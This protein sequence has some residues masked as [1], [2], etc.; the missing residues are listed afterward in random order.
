MRGAIVGAWRSAGWE[1]GHYGYPTSDE[2]CRTMA[3]GAGRCRQTYQGGA[4]TWRSDIGVIDCARLKCIAL[5]FDDG[6]S[7]Y[8]SRLVDILDANNVNATFFAVGQNVGGYPST[9]RRSYEK[10][11]EIMNHSWSHPDLT[12]LSA[13][14]VSSEL[15]R[16]SDAIG[17]TVG[18]RPTLVRPPYGSYNSTV[19]SVAGQQGMAVILWNNDTLDWSNRNTA[20][21]ISRATSSATPGGIILMHDLYPTTVDA[22]PTIIG[23]LK[24]RGYALVSVS[25]VIGNP[26]P[27]RVYSRRP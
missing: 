10:G 27:G 24:A 6:P 26:Q 23:N 5:T 8:T 14:G 2:L 17:S 3:G 16:T 12:G 25:D 18:R 9:V 15:S 19:T 7:Q 22:V 21:I 13:S 4:I 20:T 11:N 1:N